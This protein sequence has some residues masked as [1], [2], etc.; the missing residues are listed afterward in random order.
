MKKK[1]IALLLTALLLSGC[2][3]QQQMTDIIAFF[4]LWCLDNGYL[5]D[6]GF[7]KIDLMI[8]DFIAARTADA[9]EQGILDSIDAFTKGP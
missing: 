3:I 6:D 8:Q 4:Q 1:L 5:N 7:P 9:V 2:S